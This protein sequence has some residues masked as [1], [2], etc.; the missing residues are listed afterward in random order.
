MESSGGHS[1]GANKESAFRADEESKK[2]EAEQKVEPAPKRRFVV[3]Y[4]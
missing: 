4:Q 2:R 1:K 3:F